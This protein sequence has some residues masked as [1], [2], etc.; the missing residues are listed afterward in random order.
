M[1]LVH[2]TIVN[3]STVVNL[4][5]FFIAYLQKCSEINQTKLGNNTATLVRPSDHE[6]RLGLS[7]ASF[8]ARITKHTSATL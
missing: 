7:H 1:K 8:T 5:I 3:N 6:T 4:Y 2:I